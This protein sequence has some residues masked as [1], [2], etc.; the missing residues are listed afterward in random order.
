MNRVSHRSVSSLAAVGEAD[1]HHQFVVLRLGGREYALPARAVVQVL[2][3]VAI[4]PV[5]ES[6]MWISGVINLRGR[7]T[8]MLDLRKRLGLPA[9]TPGLSA[10]IVIVRSNDAILG[11]I[12]DA[13]LEVLAL[14]EDAVEPPGGAAGRS[15]VISGVARSNDRLILVLDVDRLLVDSVC[16][17][18][19]LDPIEA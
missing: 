3:M 8:P 14:D 10:H 15:R 4:R 5:P 6:P 1:E 11:L 2:R 18:L 7:M 16:P 19:D 12:A 17:S 9:E 13:V